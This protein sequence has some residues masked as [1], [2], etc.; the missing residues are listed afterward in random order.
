MVPMSKA[1]YKE[2]PEASKNFEKLARAVLQV[3]KMEPKKQPKKANRHKT[4]RSGKG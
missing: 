4:S 1:E 2:G 3:P